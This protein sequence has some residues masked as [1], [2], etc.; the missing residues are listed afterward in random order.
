MISENMVL[1]NGTFAIT[2]KIIPL[3]FLEKKISNLTNK[4][5]KELKNST[6]QCNVYINRT[7]GQAVKCPDK[8]CK[9]IYSR[10]KA[11]LYPDLP[12][13]GKKK[14][15]KKNVPCMGAETRQI[16]KINWPMQATC[17]RD[18]DMIVE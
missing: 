1:R 9:E 6:K 2:L 12:D 3:I 10:K 14:K 11:H 17:L 5:M 4:N 8:L 18:Y 13:R 16:K 15:K 7:A